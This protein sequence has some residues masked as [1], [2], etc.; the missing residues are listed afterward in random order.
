MLKKE[1]NN[2]WLTGK[3][4][5][6]ATGNINKFKEARS[7]LSSY[8]IALGMIKLKGDEI[9][10]ESIQKLLKKVLLMHTNVATRQYLLKTLV[11]LLTR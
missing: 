7:I 5:F 1:D 11:Y 4:V 6:F 2:L 3:V 10:S 9:Q 8:G